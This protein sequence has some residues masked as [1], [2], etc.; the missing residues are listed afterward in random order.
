MYVLTNQSNRG[1]ARP[2]ANVVY[3]SG[4]KRNQILFQ[5]P[6]F[7][8]QRLRSCGKSESLLIL[9]RIVEQNLTSALVLEDDVDWDLRIKSQMHDF[10]KASIVLI[11]PVPGTDHPLDPTYPEPS[12]GQ[13]STDFDVKIE[14]IT[15]SYSSPYGDIARW[16]LLWL[17]HCG[18][19]FPRAS[20]QN[21]PLGR[22]VIYGDETVPEPQH[23]D[24]QFGT[25][26]LTTEYSP[27]TRVVPRARVNTCILSKPMWRMYRPALILRPRKY[28]VWSLTLALL[29]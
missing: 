19:R 20:D 11:Q 27:H 26:E 10:A 2:V 4:D 3:I 23:I 21:A 29:L 24:M 28:L 9:S 13:T 6:S 5:R 17:G 8:Y 7:S 16:D 22:A 12:H 1:S 25:P 14:E 18:C 15:N